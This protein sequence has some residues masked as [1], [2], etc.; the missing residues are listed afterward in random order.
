VTQAF[1]ILVSDE[2]DKPLDV[3]GSRLGQQDKG[4]HTD[5]VDNNRKLL[6]NCV[7]GLRLLEKLENIFE[8]CVG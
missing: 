5:L 6:V 1:D 2:R 8:W 4:V 7:V 3:Y